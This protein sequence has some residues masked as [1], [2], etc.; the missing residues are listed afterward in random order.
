M[1]GAP[2]EGGVGRPVELT[3]EGGTQIADPLSEGIA[4]RA[5]ATASTAGGAD[6]RARAVLP[7]IRRVS[8]SIAA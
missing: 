3:L 5:Q 7:T 4:A 6:E 8:P 2:V 1:G